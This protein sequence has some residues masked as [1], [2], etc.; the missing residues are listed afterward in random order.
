MNKGCERAFQTR[1]ESWSRK[2]LLQRGHPAD[3]HQGPE[4][5]SVKSRN[6]SARKPPCSSPRVLSLNQWDYHRV[7]TPITKNKKIAVSLS[8]RTSPQASDG[9]IW[10]SEGSCSGLC[11]VLLGVLPGLHSSGFSPAS[12]LCFPR[13]ASG[14]PPPPLSFIYARAHMDTHQH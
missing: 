14:L 5:T 7:F 11:G 3:A 10:G 9:G 2:W 8:H 4:K 1:R 12:S 6:A 13:V